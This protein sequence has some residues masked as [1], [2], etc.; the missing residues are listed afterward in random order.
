M[1]YH[2]RS[3]R[4]RGFDYA[5]NGYYFVTICCQDRKNI[6]GEIKNNQIILN[7]FGKLVLKI[8]NGIP[9]NNFEI[10]IDEFCVMPN[11]IHGILIINRR[12]VIHHALNNNELNQGAINGTEKGAMN[13][14]LMNLKGAINC[15]PT[16]G[17]IIRCFKS[18][19]TYE[20]NKI[21]QINGLKIWQRNY[22]ERIIRNEKEYLKIKEYI[23]NNP[24][25]WN[26]D[27][28]NIF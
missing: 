15:A 6:F 28:N 5:N 13:E 18:R 17:Q 21:N 7:D 16:I 19:C 3:I 23:K 22:F 8:W 4:L 27:R 10:E 1:I 2:R 26:R 14:G 24:K 9:N 11:H 25:M 12:G 20:I